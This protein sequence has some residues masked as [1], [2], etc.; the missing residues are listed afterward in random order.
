MLRQ[1][2]GGAKVVMVVEVPNGKKA[3]ETW[4]KKRGVAHGPGP[5]RATKKPLTCKTAL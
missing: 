4:G 2:G 3:L 5:S 1:E